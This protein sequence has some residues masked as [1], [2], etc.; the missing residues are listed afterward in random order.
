MGTGGP[1][2]GVKRSGHE[3]RSL[4]LEGKDDPKVFLYSQY[5]KQKLPIVQT[6]RIY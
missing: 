1:F 5:K 6:F 3:F 4:F 2:Q